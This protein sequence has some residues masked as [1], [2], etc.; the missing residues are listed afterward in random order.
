MKRLLFVLPTLHPGGAERNAIGVANYLTETHGYRITLFVFD[1]AATLLPLID[2][3]IKV[4][5]GNH[6]R[7]TTSKAGWLFSYYLTMGR[8]LS[9]SVDA[10]EYDHIISIH[11]HVPEIACFILWF[12]NLFRGKNLRKKLITVIQISLIG[13]MEQSMSVS[14]AL[15]HA[16]LKAVRKRIFG[17]MIVLSEKMKKQMMHQHSDITVIPNMIEIDR[18]LEESKYP[19]S[20]PRLKDPYLLSVARISPQKNPMFLL[21]SFHAVLPT[22]RC[23]LVFLGSVQNEQ[24]FSEMNAYIR[25][26]GLE[27][28]IFILG[29]VQQPYALMKHAVSVVLGSDYEGL[30]L[31]VLEAIAL[32]VPVI[33]TKYEGVEEYFSEQTV[34][35]VERGSVD[36][37]SRAMTAAGNRDPR[38]S[39]NAERAFAMIR[40]HDISQ[41]GMMYHNVFTTGGV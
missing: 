12:V 35:L 40:S 30:P 11:E 4:I 20:D 19:V 13:R 33:M 9:R 21:R 6:R 28:R 8:T 10:D 39:E 3:K 23:N 32:K 17:K 38:L 24:L 34:I 27:E 36:L 31:S 15:L 16:F 25:D 18:I 22:I 7:R 14:A 41:I 29:A 37:M 26:H 2:K 1:D 5:H